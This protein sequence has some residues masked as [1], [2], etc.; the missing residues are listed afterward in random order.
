MKVWLGNSRGCQEEMC[1]VNINGLEK[2]SSFVVGE[3]CAI[4]L[5]GEG[6][7]CKCQWTWE[8]GSPLLGR[9]CS[10]AAPRV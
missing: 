2:G 3:I 8:K 1:N 6:V 10:L 5:S 4:L 7:E 9:L